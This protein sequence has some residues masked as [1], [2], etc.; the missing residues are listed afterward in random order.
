MSK[1]R[2]TILLMIIIFSISVA[3]I[4]NNILENTIRTMALP[5]TNKAIVI[6]AGHRR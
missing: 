5:A 1:K 4:K 2:I 3:N 6:D